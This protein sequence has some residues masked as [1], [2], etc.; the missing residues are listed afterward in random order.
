MI[1]LVEIPPRS[2][3]LSPFLRSPDTLELTSLKMADRTSLWLRAASASRLIGGGF[4]CVPPAGNRQPEAD[5]RLNVLISDTCVFSQLL[6]FNIE[7]LKY[8]KSYSRF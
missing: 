4:H 6:S 7:Y 5:L 2:A 3:P 8:F 1:L